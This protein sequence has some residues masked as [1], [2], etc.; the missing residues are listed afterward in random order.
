MGFLFFLTRFRVRIEELFVGRTILTDF[1]KRGNWVFEI[2][3]GF[4]SLTAY[5]TEEESF[6]DEGEDHFGGVLD[7]PTAYSVEKLV[8]P[9]GIFPGKGI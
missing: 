5:I 2:T 8:G 6:F 7:S 3:S 4:S 9:G 1:C